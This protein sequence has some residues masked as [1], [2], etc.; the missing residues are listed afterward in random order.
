MIQ[1]KYIQKR[2]RPTNIENKFLTSKGESEE[3]I[4]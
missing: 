4:H 3:G 1:M 2:N